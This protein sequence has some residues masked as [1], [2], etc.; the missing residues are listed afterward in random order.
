MRQAFPSLDDKSIIT[1]GSFHFAI[2]SNYQPVGDGTFRKCHP[3]SLGRFLS[4]KQ[5]GG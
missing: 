2:S 3:A 5:S 4:I 1:S